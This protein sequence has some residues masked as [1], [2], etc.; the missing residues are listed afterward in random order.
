M[1]HKMPV[2]KVRPPF[3]TEAFYSSVTPLFIF[4]SPSRQ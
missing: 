4:L 3:V 2:A 1:G